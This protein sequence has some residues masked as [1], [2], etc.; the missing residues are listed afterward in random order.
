M[1]GSA[2]DGAIAAGALEARDPANTPL[3][4]EALEGL[5]DRGCVEG[6][7]SAGAP[8]RFR[9]GGQAGTDDRQAAELN[10][11]VADWEPED[12]ELDA[13]IARLCEQLTHSGRGD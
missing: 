7:G 8:D 5:N 9:R 13:M 6:T 11:L 10:L 12:P 2:E 1:L 4:L 3:L